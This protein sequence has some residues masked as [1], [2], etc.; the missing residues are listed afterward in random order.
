MPP[1]ISTPRAALARGGVSW[2]TALLLLLVAGGGFLAWTWTPVWMMHIEVKQCVRDYM[3]R[4]IKNRND[5]VLLQKMSDELRRR[6]AQEMPGE[7]GELVEA[8]AVDLG[9]ADV[10][11]ER[12]EGD[13]PTLH[14][15]FEYT[16]PVHYPLVDRWTEITLEVDLVNE[17]TH[18]EWGQSR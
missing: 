3:N 7:D 4:A 9:P 14:V 17:L 10:I 1:I 8:S 18:A 11:W 6:T 15:Q 2:V 12:E 16:R 13:P 5:A